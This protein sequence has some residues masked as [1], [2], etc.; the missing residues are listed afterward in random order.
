MSMNNNELF[1]DEEF[2]VFDLWGP[3]TDTTEPD[4][5]LARIITDDEDYYEDEY[6]DSDE[7]D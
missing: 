2:P 1:D 3:D 4:D 6:F 7:L 5:L